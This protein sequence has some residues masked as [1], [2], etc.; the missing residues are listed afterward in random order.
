MCIQLLLVS[1]LLSA[2]GFP[3]FIAK[4]ILEAYVTFSVSEVEF[5]S[6]ANRCTHTSDTTVQHTS[7]N[8]GYKR[9]KL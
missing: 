8:Y 9:L 6:L 4:G 1:G 7:V 5:N 3:F 2:F